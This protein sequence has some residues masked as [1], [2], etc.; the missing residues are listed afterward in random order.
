MSAF[1]SSTKPDWYTSSQEPKSCP[2]RKRGLFLILDAHS[3]KLAKGS[4][5]TDFQGFSGLIHSSD[6]F[7]LV[8]KY[9]FQ[10]RPG[11][12]FINIL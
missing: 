10:I 9:G 8:S 6:S 5:D 2:G 1:G 12:N 3:D 4:V 11:V 7:P